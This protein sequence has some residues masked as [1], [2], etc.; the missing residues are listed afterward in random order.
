MTA[1]TTA[2]GQ[3]STRRPAY[4]AVYDSQKDFSGS[5]MGTRYARAAMIIRN[6]VADAVFVEDVP[7]VTASGAPAILMAL[8]A[9]PA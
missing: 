6:G 3:M 2:H 4:D 1:E 5:G 8:E 9:A 7:G